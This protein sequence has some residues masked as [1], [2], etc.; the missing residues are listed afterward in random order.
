MNMRRYIRQWWKDWYFTFS[1]ELRMIFSDSG[2]LIIFF[3]AGLAY[4]I[5]YGI[6]YRKVVCMY[7]RIYPYIRVVYLF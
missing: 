2:V 4:P 7:D 6:V 1:N 5:I 3:L